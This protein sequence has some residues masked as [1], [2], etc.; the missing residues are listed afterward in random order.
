MNAQNSKPSKNEWIGLYVPKH[1]AKLILR[2]IADNTLPLL[3]T[4]NDY[5]NVRPIFNAN[6]GYILAAKDLIPAQ[7]VKINNG[8]K[9]NIVGT[10][11][12][13]NKAGTHIKEGEKGL[14]YNWQDEDKQ[15]HHSALFFAEQT[16]DPEKFLENVQ[17]KQLQRLQ[18]VTF[19]INTPEE[20]LP[21]YLA[22]AKSGASL[23]VSTEVARKFTD[24]LRHLCKEEFMTNFNT[25]PHTIL[26]SVLFAADI[27]A[28][29]IVKATEQK[30]GVTPTYT[31][32]KK[33]E[34]SMRR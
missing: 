28:N 33:I 24:Q 22:A 2:G 34:K 4:K 9:G 12:T 1:T 15:F 7:I 3:P 16:V 20:Y 13:I 14:W 32:E 26:H 30:R 10:K 21:M 27:E 23:T 6:T 29:K 25:E 8:Y 18:A 5:I 11:N 19:K 31:H 17:I